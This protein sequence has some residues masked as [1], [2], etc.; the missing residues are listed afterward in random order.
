M[1]G[2]KST[3]KTIEETEFAFS[4]LSVIEWFN[5]IQTLDLG[6]D[7]VE[8]TS[9]SVSHHMEVEKTVAYSS[10]PPARRE[11]LRREESIV[12]AD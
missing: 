12:L 9:F 10:Q 1:C 7:F 6:P 8:H 3:A 2:V 5:H 11:N 4:L